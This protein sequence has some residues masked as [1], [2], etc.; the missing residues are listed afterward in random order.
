MT[1]MPPEDPLKEHGKHNTR[2]QTGMEIQHKNHLAT[3]CPNNDYNQRHLLNA[4][5][6]WKRYLDF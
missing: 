6:I 3:K 5:I 4:I 2:I 1:I